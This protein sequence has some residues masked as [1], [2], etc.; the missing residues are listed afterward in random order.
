MDIHIPLVIWIT[1]KSKTQYPTSNFTANL[2]AMASGTRK[3]LAK[4]FPHLGA[5]ISMSK[6][7]NITLLI[8]PHI[9]GNLLGIRTHSWQIKNRRFKTRLHLII[10]IHILYSSKKPP[11]GGNIITANWV[12]N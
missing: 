7:I 1:L 4:S 9:L 12:T 8:K 11:F 5:S 3:R 6:S 2:I 10:H